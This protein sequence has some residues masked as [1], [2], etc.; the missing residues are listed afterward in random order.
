M[1]VGRE[2]GVREG[3]LC[4]GVEE[5]PGHREQYKWRPDA[6]LLR[7]HRTGWEGLS[8]VTGDRMHL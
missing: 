7:T 3:S 8:R 6:G 5:D 1:V 2:H 4:G